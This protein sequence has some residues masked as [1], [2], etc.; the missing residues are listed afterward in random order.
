MESPRFLDEH[1]NVYWLRP[2]SALWD[3]IASTVIS[4]FPLLSPSLDLGSGNGIFSF[5]TAGG[6][7]SLDY[8]WYRN[9]D[10]TGFWDNQDI[11]D[12]YILSPK[13]EWLIR[14]PKYQIDSA[15]DAKRNLLNQAE[16]L[17]FYRETI[18]ADANLRFPFKDD[19]FQTIFS[20][21]LYWLHSAEFSLQEIWRV[22]RPGG[23]ALLCLQDHKFKEFCLSYQWRQ[24]NSQVLRLLN[25]GR[26]ESSY[27][28]ISYPELKA[29]AQKFHF[30]VVHHSYYLSPLTLKVWDI[31]LRPLSPV[32][33]K[34]VHKLNEQERLTIKSEWI[35][36]VRPFLIELYNLDRN[37][38]KQGG[39]HFVCLEKV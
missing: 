3:A 17:H 18:V 12:S 36:T 33:I 6:A 2:E 35:E 9:V 1:L 11:Y 19:T 20:N 10:P 7:F 28:T 31:G 8:D 25:R 23:Y 5:I 4:E 13:P 39:Y 15:M 38:E 14:Q 16:A 24:Q 32:L 34:M 26:S 22:L 30:K 37:S 29:L 27:W 21:I